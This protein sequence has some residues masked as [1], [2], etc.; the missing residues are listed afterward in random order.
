MISV[1]KKFN[2]FARSSCTSPPVVK[3]EVSMVKISQLFFMQSHVQLARV[4]CAVTLLAHLKKFH[5]SARRRSEKN[6]NC[7]WKSLR[8]VKDFSRLALSKRLIKQ[9]KRI[10]SP[11]FKTVLTQFS[12]NWKVFYV[13]KG[14]KSFQHWQLAAMSSKNEKARTMS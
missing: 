6:K 3:K 4:H 11:V 7:K 14:F 10:S 9:L 5:H 8:K 2:C 13:A 12:F 1:N